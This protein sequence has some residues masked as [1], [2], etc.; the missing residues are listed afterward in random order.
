MNVTARGVACSGRERQNCSS[1]NVGLFQFNNKHPILTRCV[2]VNAVRSGVA[3][4]RL[5]QNAVF[6]A[7]DHRGWSL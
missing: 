5:R 2:V 7:A 4:R 3:G 6:L 1:V